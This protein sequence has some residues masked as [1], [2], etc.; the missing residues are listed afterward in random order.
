MDKWQDAWDYYFPTIRMWRRR[1]RT[2]MA[3]GRT[4]GRF[5]NGTTYTRN[6]FHRR[7]HD[8]RNS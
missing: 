5:Q 1:G 8:E 7:P 3:D 4:I 6:A 2:K